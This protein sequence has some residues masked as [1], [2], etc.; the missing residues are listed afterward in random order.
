MNSSAYEADHNNDSLRNDK[1]SHQTQRY[2]ICRTVSQVLK[3][4]PG[5]VGKLILLS[6][7]YENYG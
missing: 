5:H 2:D 3:S 4:Q 6:V 7:A 1:V